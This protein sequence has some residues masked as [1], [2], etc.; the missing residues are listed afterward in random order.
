[1]CCVVCC[2]LSCVLCVLEILMGQVPGRKLSAVFADYPWL[3]RSLVD[4]SEA[5]PGHAYETLAM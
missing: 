2:M 3:G 5:E 4:T 1:M